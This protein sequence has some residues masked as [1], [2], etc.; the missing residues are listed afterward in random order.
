MRVLFANT[1]PEDNDDDHDGVCQVIDEAGQQELYAVALY[2]QK[3]ICQYKLL[4][5]MTT[6]LPPLML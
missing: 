2:V 1:Q 3:D 6:M 5:S 4:T